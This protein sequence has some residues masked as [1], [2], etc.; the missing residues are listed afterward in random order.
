MNSQEERFSGF[1]GGELSVGYGDASGR[2]MQLIYSTSTSEIWVAVAGGRRRVYK[3][4]AAGVRRSDPYVRLLRKEFDVMSRLSH[5]GVVMAFDF[6]EDPARGEAIEM[7]WIDGS[8]LGR[9]LSERP[10]R[11][12][13]RRVAMQ[14]LDAVE[15]VHSKGVVHRDLK[16]S[17]ILITHDGTFV[18]IIDFG[19]ADTAA[20][21]ELKNPA[22]TEGYM[23]DHQREAFES[24]IS[25]DLFALRAVLGEVLPG[26]ARWLSGHCFDSIGALRKALTTR[27]R[28]PARIARAVMAVGLVAMMA[29]IGLAAWWLTDR[30]RA[31]QQAELE[32]SEA[33][34]RRE[35]E[36]SETTHRQTVNRLHDSIAQLSGRAEQLGNQTD[37]LSAATDR[38]S[39]ETRSQRA[40]V[41]ASARRQARVNDIIA[42]QSRRIGAVWSN[43]PT[44][45]V[46]GAEYD[47]LKSGHAIIRQCLDQHRGDLSAADLASIETAL[48]AEHKKH[49]DQWKRNKPTPAP[50]EN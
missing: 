8:T 4:L 5:P 26:D 25:D 7:E 19:L 35:I 15:Y 42:E 36:A 17:N 28:R 11:A 20:H 1:V 39:D 14:I 45:S 43:P 24:L 48:T 31:S 27:W 21:V 9:W 12:A 49:Y 40:V 16:P 13:R 22:G 47:M 10:D 46:N 2:D 50:T 3:T 29:G 32:R 37:R 18:K 34:L 44:G 23:S 38:L 33:Q 30:Q 41:D 6:R